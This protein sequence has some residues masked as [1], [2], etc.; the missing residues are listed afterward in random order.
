M[1]F[2][3]NHGFLTTKVLLISIITILLFSFIIPFSASDIIVN[4]GGVSTDFSVTTGSVFNVCSCTSGADTVLIKNTGTF[5]ANFVI[6]SNLDYVLFSESNFF[7][8]PGEIKIITLTV[9]DLCTEKKDSMLLTIS[10]NLGVVKSVKK[11]LTIGPCQNLKV[12]MIAYNNSINP[13]NSALYTIY[14]QNIGTF[15]ETYNIKS[16]YDENINYSSKQFK[17]KPGE[18]K[19]INVSL[20]FDCNINGEYKI[21]FVVETKTTKL[22]AELEHN[23]R[24]EKNYS[25]SLNAN[26]EQ[27]ACLFQ[28]SK[29][30]FNIK[31]EVFFSNKYKIIVKVQDGLRVSYLKQVILN[32]FE[33][34]Q[35]EILIK[36]EKKPGFH[37]LIIVV[38]DELGKVKKELPIKVEQV[39]CWNLV[40]NLDTP[41]EPLCPGT[42][43]YMM[44][45]TNLGK[46][47]E[48]ISI[49]ITDEDFIPEKNDFIIKP[50][51]Y[52]HTKIFF[53]SPDIDKSSNVTVTVNSFGYLKFSQSFEV[54]SLSSHS[55]YYVNIPIKKVTARYDANNVL[56]KIRNDGRIYNDYFLTADTPNWVDLETKNVE[57]NSKEEKRISFVLNRNEEFGPGDYNITLYART[58]TPNITYEIPLILH[59]RDK[60]IFEKAYEYIFFDLTRL[61]IFILALI[62]LI[63]LILLII[64]IIRAPKYLMKFSTRIEKNMNLMYWLLAI[65]LIVALLLVV[66]FG[67]PD[68]PKAYHA[69]TNSSALYFEWP[70]DTKYKVNLSNYFND[71]DMDL[72]TYSIS[73]VENIEAEIIRDTLIL[74]PKK[75]FYGKETAI[76][77]AFDSQGGETLSDPITLSVVQVVKPTFMQYMSAIKYYLILIPLLLILFL[78]FLIAI[79]SYRRPLPGKRKK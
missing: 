11:Q 58:Y 42:Y 52:D 68:L 18:L 22:K 41:K 56:Y 23:L 55:C 44:N 67:I 31:N 6:E 36:K 21:P 51:E 71:P 48:N 24:I 77:T 57:L 16:K 29:V 28:D 17:L 62:L 3:K 74:T 34:K 35:I 45:F 33:D 76:I 72:L 19:E 78:I 46:F 75:G 49:S 53:D 8:A 30:Y 63:L 66:V 1:K 65:W 7:L 32:G 73:G 5:P 13:C 12:S 14:V 25:Y 2:I 20:K 27:I 69:E 59:I 4:P 50:G 47:D 39:N 38:E 43:E 40:V 54:K 37:T 61:I 60:N 15:E 9:F 70:Q 10:S 64:T 79:Y 26:S